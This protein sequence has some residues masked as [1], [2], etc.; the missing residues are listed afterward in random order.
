MDRLDQDLSGPDPSS[1]CRRSTP[2]PHSRN[3]NCSP[4]TGMDPIQQKVLQ[5]M[6]VAFAV[7][8]VFFPAGLVLYWTVSNLLQIAQQW[9]INRML[10]R[11]NAAAAAAAK[12]WRFAMTSDE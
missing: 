3:P 11:D 2:S 1:C 12:R 5:Y 10:E 7:M 8:F 9:Q 4:G 6:P